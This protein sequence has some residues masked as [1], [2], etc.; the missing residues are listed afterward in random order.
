MLQYIHHLI[1]SGEIVHC[2]FGTI[3]GVHSILN[4]VGHDATVWSWQ[5]SIIIAGA[6]EVR[7]V[8][9]VTH[10]DILSIYI[11][12]LRQSIQTAYQVSLHPLYQ[13]EFVLWIT[14]FCWKMPQAQVKLNEKKIPEVPCWPKSHSVFSALKNGRPFNCVVITIASRVVAY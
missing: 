13:K 3:R 8:V 11:S 10:V 7:K 14:L 5:I 12:R 6:T 2:L 9:K 4:K 1:H